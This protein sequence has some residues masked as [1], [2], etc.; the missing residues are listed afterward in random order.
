M[1][2]PSPS[3]PVPALFQVF[4]RKAEVNPRDVAE[5]FDC[6]QVEHLPYREFDS[7]D[8]SPVCKLRSSAPAPRLPVPQPLPAKRASQPLTVLRSRQR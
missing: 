3:V 7:F 6:L 4:S 5:L 8:E 1:A 2:Y